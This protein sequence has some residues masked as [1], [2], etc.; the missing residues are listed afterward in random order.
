[1]CTPPTQL[2]V[3]GWIRSIVWMVQMARMDGLPSTAMCTC[4]AT[5]DTAALL[6]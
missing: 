6:A 3:M 5:S 2:Q 1:M 4:K